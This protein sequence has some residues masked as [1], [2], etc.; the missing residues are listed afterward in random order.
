MKGYIRIA[1]AL[2]TLVGILA[3]CNRDTI[4]PD[5]N[6]APAGYRTVEFVAQVPDMNQVQTRAVDPDGGGV[7]NMTIFCFD[8]NSLFITTVNVKDIVR[9]EIVAGNASM[10]GK[11]KVNIP[12]HAVY[13]QLV[14]NQNLTYFDE[15]NY[16]GMSEVEVMSTLQASAGRMIYWA[17]KTVDEL[18][19]HNTDANPVKLIRN[20]AKFTLEVA[21][22]VPFVQKGWIVVNTNAYGTVAPYCAEHGFEAPH[23]IDRPFVTLAED[24]TK[25]SEF[26]DVRTNPEEFVFETENTIAEP[27]DFIVK[28]SYN[29]GPDL[30]YRVSIIDK[31]GENI[32]IY[33]NHHYKVNIDGELYYGQPTFAQALEAPATNNVWVAVS[34]E[35]KSISDGT[36][37]LSVAQTAYVIAEKDMPAYDSYYY[38]DYE[39][40]GTEQVEV[41]W[42]GDNNVARYNLSHTAGRIGVT[43]NAMGGLSKREGTL[44]IKA[45]RLSRKVKI[46]T[47]KEQSFVPAWITTNVYG[48]KPGEHVTMMFTIPDDC[49]QE[50]FPMDVLVSVND[51]DVRNESGMVLPVITATD[52]PE[53]YGADN[54]IGYK[55]VLTVEGTGKQRIYLETILSHD[56]NATVNVMIEAEHFVPVT[57]TA[58]FKHAENK[59]II[60]DN[61]RHYTAAIP[62]DEVIHYYLV[63]QKINAPVELVAHLG[64]NAVW[65]TAT[66]EY[67]YTPLVPDPADE[68]L[69]YS[70]YLD[71]NDGVDASQY[72]FNF[73]DFNPD[74]WSTGGRVQGFYRSENSHALSTDRTVFYL[75]TNSAKSAE[76]VRIASN[77]NGSQSVTG[78]GT[79]AGNDYKS[80]VF[81]LA[82]YHPFHFAATVDEYGQTVTGETP[83][84]VDEAYVS[85][86]PGSKVIVSFDVKA[87]KSATRGD[88]G[89]VLPDS[90]QVMVDPFG[91]AFDI[92][93]DA[94]MLEIDPSDPLYAAGK[95]TVNDGRFVYHVAA[96]QASEDS[97][98]SNG[99]KSI[100]FRTKNIVSA[101]EI[102]ITSDKSKVVYYDKT[103]RVQN[104]SITGKIQYKPAGGS[105]TDIPAGSFVPFEVLPTYNRIGTVDV[106]NSG[107]F[108]LRLRSEYRYN[109]TVDDV[110]LQFNDGGTVYEATFGSLEELYNHVS[111][112]KAIILQ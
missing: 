109:W 97:F 1:A 27:V 94:P 100:R 58:T 112:G 60:I 54:G 76:V 15:D 47:I 19:A 82:N 59:S 46:I 62:N 9:D 103:F 67:D 111:A 110:K 106:N 43:L 16:R 52:D 86:E 13:L 66:G 12:D 98:G 21:G 5:M 23:Y 105:A 45:G 7:Q 8:A 99:R 70:R 89:Q 29:G 37:T 10:G 18:K 75:K 78:S 4:I 74:L 90:E 22:N 79:C 44:L 2:A 87:F 95:V 73:K 28:G 84:T 6:D 108:Q 81:E 69:M 48:G 20:Q 64:Q 68:F 17:R 85:Y 31:D 77:P 91:T 92:Y 57:K 101:G 11:F 30:Y 80:V 3:S 25:L 104:E 49:P 61:L 38:I 24:V 88:N 96:S 42:T 107:N 71:H 55:Y 14:G 93:I 56:E 51:M 36:N 53:R 41:S 35:I 33:R 63:P 65:N 72:Y 102:T 26:I 34:D 40:D 50:L 39:Y 32:P 83:E